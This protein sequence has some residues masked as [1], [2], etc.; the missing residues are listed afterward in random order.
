MRFDQ[1]AAFADAAAFRIRST[2]CS[3]AFG[4]ITGTPGNHYASPITA[5]RQYQQDR[6]LTYL[7]AGTSRMSHST[8]V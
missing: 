6:V 3:F 1:F 7:T 4:I 5:E 8:D 2:A